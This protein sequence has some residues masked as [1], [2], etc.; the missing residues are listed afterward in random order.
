MTKK[1]EFRAFDFAASVP[2]AISED[3]LENILAIARRENDIEAVQARLGRPLQNTRNVSMRDDVAVIPVTGPI[4]RYAN[5]FTEISGAVSLSTLAT[6]FNEALTN[7]RVKAI[8]LEIDSPGG[9][10][11]GISEF[12]NM[13]R[14]AGKPVVAYV[15]NQGAS[16]A[17]WIAAAA[18]QIVMSDTAMVGSIGVIAGFTTEKESGR[19]EIVSSQSP[20]KRVDASTE[21]GRKTIQAT[22][23]DLAEVFVSAV[24]QFRGV[25]RETVI[26]KFGEG[27]VLVG[28]F[29][30]AVGMADSLGSLESVIAGLSGS[31]TKSRG[32]IM[33]QENKPEAG[34]VMSLEKFKADYPAI[35]QAAHSEGMEAGKAAE[36][37]RIKDVEAS[38]L[39]GHEA[40]IA[41]LK[42]D[43]K[44]TGGEAATAVLKAEKE[45]RST[46][47]DQ[48][49]ASAPKPVAQPA[50][51]PVQAAAPNLDAPLDER[52]KKAWDSDANLRAEFGGD[53]AAYLSFEQASVDGLVKINSKKG[54]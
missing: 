5:M 47:L 14:A 26:T 24:A 10:A 18:N 44:T 45:N 50:Q 29:A 15:S 16:A 17:Y 32:A 34:P 2:W 43:G 39:P 35:Y 9:Q 31:E 7:S 11:S 3:A 27:G 42:F 36:M 53:F 30:V 51:D 41:A 22:V 33:A 13:I 54:A 20:K 37:Q 25:D 46:A 49:K 40:L 48:F 23:D 19:I 4:F 21:E 38:G 28:K 12:A 52:C 6:D 1:T 8:V